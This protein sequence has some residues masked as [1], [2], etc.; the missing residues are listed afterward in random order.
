MK[1][2]SDK[3]LNKAIRQIQNQFAKVNAAEEIHEIEDVVD[4][5]RALMEEATIM[6]PGT[7][8]LAYFRDPATAVFDHGYGVAKLYRHESSEQAGR[9]FVSVDVFSAEDR[10]HLC[11]VQRFTDGIW[12]C[13]E[14]T[15]VLTTADGGLALVERSPEMSQK[16]Y[17][18]EHSDL[19]R[20]TVTLVESATGAPLQYTVAIDCCDIGLVNDG[21]GNAVTDLIWLPFDGMCLGVQKLAASYHIWLEDINAGDEKNVNIH[22]VC[23][24]N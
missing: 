7:E 8:R 24:Y 15:Q 13:T 12:E 4:F 14:M 9:A 17:Y 1:A 22:R 18:T 23:G 16:E 20:I 10:Y 11:V 3:K 2:V 5:Q 19:Q 21:N 6:R